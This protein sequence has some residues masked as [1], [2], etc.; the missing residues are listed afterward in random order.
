MTHVVLQA[1]SVVLA[2][3][4][5][6]PGP[7]GQAL[8]SPPTE[9]PRAEAPWQRLLTG[10]DAKQV[11]ELERKVVELYEAG[12][13]AEAQVPARASVALRTRLQGATHW[14][15]VSMQRTLETLAQIASLSPD[16]QVELT[17]AT[18]LEKELATFQQEGRYRD[19]MSVARRVV[20]LR[21]RHLGEEHPIVARARNDLG[22]FVQHAGQHAEAETL[23]RQ[24]LAICQKRLGAEHPGTASAL[25]NLALSLDAQDKY[26]EAGPLFRQVLAIRLQAQGEDHAARD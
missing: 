8:P 5:L 20:A 13:Y 15:T 14:Q 17:E 11:E 3:S 26:A 23:F 2:V 16:A 22:I 12:R 7:T 25:T 4:L 21:Q 1:G 18:K 10:D 24:A 6:Q 19:G 9:K